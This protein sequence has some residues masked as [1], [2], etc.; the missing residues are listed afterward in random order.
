[1]AR[2]EDEED[3]DAAAF[4]VAIEPARPALP[5]TSR[6][7]RPAA[8]SLHGAASKAHFDCAFTCQQIEYKRVLECRAD[9]STRNAADVDASAS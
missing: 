3:D 9:A 7:A 6:S 5:S 1:M 8:L 2:F 4:A